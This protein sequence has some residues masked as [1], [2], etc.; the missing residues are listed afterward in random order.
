MGDALCVHPPG[1]RRARRGRDR[2]AAAA[3]YSPNGCRR[4]GTAIST[5]SPA[6]YNDG[7]DEVKGEREQLGSPSETFLDSPLPSLYDM[8]NDQYGEPFK[9]KDH[10]RAIALDPQPTSNSRSARRPITFRRTASSD[11]PA[12]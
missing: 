9:P 6:A 4:P 5:R 7:D 12:H 2:P 10:E 1:R 11:S 8:F 3:R